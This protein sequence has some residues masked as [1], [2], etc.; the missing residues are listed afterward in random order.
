MI[1]QLNLTD[2]LVGNKI[3]P[4]VAFESGIF[5]G[6]EVRFRI[7]GMPKGVDEVHILAS[8]DSSSRIMELLMAT[9]AVRRYNMYLTISISIPYVPYARQD[10]VCNSGEA[11][12]L[13][14]F[15]DLINSQHYD[16]VSI[17]DPHSHVIEALINRCS[18]RN[19]HELVR[20]AFKHMTKDKKV[21]DVVLLAPDAGAL[22]KCYELSQS[23]D[24]INHLSL[25]EKLRDLHTGDIIRTK[26][27]TDDYKGRDIMIV[28]DICDGGRTFV[29]IAKKLKKANCGKIYLVVS[30][31]IF[32]KGLAVFDDLID[33]IYC[34]NSLVDPIWS[35]QESTK[36]LLTVID[37]I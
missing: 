17:Y 37:I 8:L 4:K 13:K 21:G 16:N 14:V 15:C 24:F 22:K 34:S 33:H 35:N 10:R 7:L 26:L 12:S 2:N 30:H 20:R 1:A 31:G 27:D 18:I 6:G 9:D 32:S 3:L 25:A 23:M 5:P 19:N 11:H 36:K 29:E 28:D